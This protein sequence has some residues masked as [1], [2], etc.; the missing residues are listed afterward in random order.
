MRVCIKY[1]NKPPNLPIAVADNRQEL[2][3][4]LG[5]RRNVVDSAFS[6]HVG[7]YFEMEFDEEGDINNDR[8]SNITDKQYAKPHTDISVCSDKGSRQ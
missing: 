4:M 8:N 3:D 2:A 7:T 6:H 1:D 5:I